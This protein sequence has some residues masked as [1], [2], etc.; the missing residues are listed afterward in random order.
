M[1]WYK[2]FGLRIRS[3]WDLDPEKCD[4]ISVKKPPTKQ[5]QITV[6]RQES[7][8]LICIEVKVHIKKKIE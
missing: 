1:M 7:T 8:Q 3:S 2:L 6:R 5:Y 4:R